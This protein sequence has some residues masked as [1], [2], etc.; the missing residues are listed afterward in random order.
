MRL[1]LT[2]CSGALLFACARGAAGPEPADGDAGTFTGAVGASTG[3]ANT[4]GGQ[5]PGNTTGGEPNTGGED[6]DA[7]TG[8]APASELDAG[9]LPPEV[10]CRTEALGSCASPT[11]LGE[12][13]GNNKGDTITKSDIGSAWFRIKV[14]DD[15]S[16]GFVESAM[17]IGLTLR[18]SDSV[19]FD[20]FL[21]RDGDASCSDDPFTSTKV[22]GEDALD[23]IWNAAGPDMGETRT[24]TI[25]VRQVSATCDTWTLEIKPHPC[26]NYSAPLG[27]T[28]ATK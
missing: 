6:A 25:E 17:G 4:G 26:N 2:L 15:D 13:I 14:R 28:C 20:L 21:Y 23:H 22:S 16:N 12:V 24:L 7:N 9:D 27:E 11:D 19:N 18:A 5:E 8:E 10:V 1:A 3:G